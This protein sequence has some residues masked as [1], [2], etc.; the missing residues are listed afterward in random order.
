M[1]NL[2]IKRAIGA[3]SYVRQIF[4]NLGE[5]TSSGHSAFALRKAARI[6]G[7]ALSLFASTASSGAEVCGFLEIYYG[8]GTV[9][10]PI[11]YYDSWNTGLPSS[12]SGGGTCGMDYRTFSSAFSGNVQQGSEL[13]AVS[14]YNFEQRTYT[15]PEGQSQCT[16]TGYF[17][18]RWSISGTSVSGDGWACVSLLP[19]E[20]LISI[21]GPSTTKALPAGPALN[22]VATVTKNGVP[23]PNKPV[24]VNLPGGSSISGY[25]DAAPFSGQ[26][27]FAYM[28]PY[29]VATMEQITATCTDCTNTAQKIITVSACEVCDKTAG[30]PIQPATGEKLQ[31][32]TDWTGAGEDPLQVTRY[33][34]SFGSL[35][36]GLGP[37]WS[38]GY[39]ASISGTSTSSFVI[40]VGTGSKVLFTLGSTPGTWTADNQKDSLVSTPTGW[41]YIRSSDQSTWLFDSTNQLLQTVTRLNGQTQ[42]MAYNAD[43][44]LTSVTNAFG[45]SL[46]LGYNAAGQLTTVTTPDGKTIGYGFDGTGRLVSVQYPDSTS[47]TYLYENASF[48]NALTGIMD[49]S[50]QRLATFTYDANGR[51]TSTQHAGGVDSFTV[52]YGSDALTTGQIYPGSSTGT[53]TPITVN[54]TDPMGNTQALTYNGG[55][56]TARLQSQSAAF[57][58]TSSVAERVF[59]F[60]TTRA[61]RETDFLNNN[62]LYTWDEVRPV[63]LTTIRAAKKTEAVTT[64]NQWHPTLDLKTAVAE[65]GLLTTYV[66]NGQPDPFNS[67]TVA[68]CAPP[69]ALLPDGSPIAVLCK[70]VEQA[71]TDANGSLGFS[72]ALQSTV[73]NRTWTWSYNAKGQILTA[74]DPLN[75]TST[76]SYYADTT[77]THALGD[78][79]SA[80]NPAGHTTQYPQYDGAGRLL[81]SIDPNGVSTTY[82]Y[83]NRQRLT[84]VNAGGQ[85]TSFTYTLTGQINRVTRP[86]TSY[87]EYAYD[88]AQRL[89]GIADSLGNSISYTLDNAGNRTAEQVKDPAGVL[90]RQV[91]RVYDQLG[92]QQQVTGLE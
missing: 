81:Q 80:S 19:S 49:E 62:T 64:T 76:Y 82:V 60:G 38:L 42:T 21:S 92:R 83:D 22:L 31:N 48:P 61:V 91:S 24:T 41:K 55:N 28:P 73:P 27:K 86:D 68:N 9:G 46:Q 16:P 87:V 58:G 47:K 26:F 12:Y 78:L 1:K 6:G 44:Q 13:Y 14:F 79:Q 4:T 63:I 32:E 20:T 88:A 57:D 54:I 25:T 15:L 51:A 29:Q 18:G 69:T 59:N 10:A 2:I 84:S 35:T 66:Y 89:T 36:S 65:P 7:I 45:R 72:A 71:T 11:G 85:V 30:N 37:N 8:G 5:T 43:K 39:V 33:Y 70:K 53:N 75:R 40:Q 3:V 67:N 52:N 34:R 17:R 90:K 77:S 56:G 23:L 50:A 74:T